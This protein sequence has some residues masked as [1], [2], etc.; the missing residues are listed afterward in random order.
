VHTESQTFGLLA[1]IAEENLEWETIVEAWGKSK[2]EF[3][4]KV[5]FNPCLERGSEVR[6]V[7]FDVLDICILC[8][9]LFDWNCTICHLF[10]HCLIKF[11]GFFQKPPGGSI[12]TARR[13]ISGVWLFLF[14]LN[15]LAAM[16]LCQAT[17]CW[18]RFFCWGCFD[19]VR[20][21]II[22]GSEIIVCR[23]H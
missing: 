6:G 14:W 1:R 19:V 10:L 2:G 7:V 13:L 23:L 12:P 3:E 15:R 17:R 21:E 22:M 9:A 18:L 16:G 5:T 11:L 20:V 4:L 8:C